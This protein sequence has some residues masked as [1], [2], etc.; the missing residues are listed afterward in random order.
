MM[1]D[2]KRLLQRFE[3]KATLN[4]FLKVS[5][6]LVKPSG[7]VFF[8]YPSEKINKV[9]KLVNLNNFYITSIQRFYHNRTSKSTLTVFQLEKSERETNYLEDLIRN[10]GT[11]KQLYQLFF[12]LN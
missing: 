4:D 2:K 11:Y 6:Y 8:I 3:V 5:N 9:R 1:Q 10:S 12:R 7:R